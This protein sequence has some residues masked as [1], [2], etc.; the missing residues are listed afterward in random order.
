MIARTADVHE[1]VLKAA[2][3]W[4]AENSV[5]KA[6]RDLN[7][8]LVRYVIRNRIDWRRCST[9]GQSILIENAPVWSP[10]VKR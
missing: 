2:A 4:Y 10:Q 8:L 5:P 3:R 9:D 6:F 1:D 7:P